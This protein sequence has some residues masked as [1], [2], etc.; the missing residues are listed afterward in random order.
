MRTIE[1]ADRNVVRDNPP[2]ALAWKPGVDVERRRFDLEG[3]SSELRQ[4][5][6]WRELRQRSSAWR[7]ER[8]RT[9]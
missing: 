2:E 4:D 3:R 1:L 5:I 7:D 9:R 6:S 8:A